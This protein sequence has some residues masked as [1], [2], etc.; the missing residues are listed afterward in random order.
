[1]IQQKSFK[2]LSLD[3]LKEFGKHSDLLGLFRQYILNKQDRVPVSD[4]PVSGPGQEILKSRFLSLM[5]VQ[6]F[7][8]TFVTGTVYGV[9]LRAKI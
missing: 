4:G 2:I 7:D 3:F 6:I 1:M 8:W 5:G 9:F